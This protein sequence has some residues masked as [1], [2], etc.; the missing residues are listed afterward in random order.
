MAYAAKLINIIGFL[1]KE[2]VTYGTAVAVAGATDAVQP[3]FADRQGIPAQLKYTYAG[4]TGAAPG[5]LG[6]IRNAVPFGATVS[7]D[8]PFF[9]K[10]GGAAYSA[11]VFPLFHKLLKA[12]GLTATG[13]FGAGTENW[14]Y[15]PTVDATVPTSLTVELYTDGEKIPLTGV[16][17]N[18]KCM[19]DGTGLVKHTFTLQGIKGVAADSASSVPAGFTIPLATVVPPS[20]A[21]VTLLIGSYTSAIG[22]KSFDWDLGR[23]LFERPGNEAADAHLGFVHGGRKPRLTVVVEKTALA[24]T[25]F[26]QAGGLDPYKLFES[27]NSFTVTLQH[28]GV[29]YNRW[30]L[31]LTQAQMIAPVDRMP[32][33]G[34]ASMKLQFMPYVSTPVANDDVSLAVD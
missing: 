10:G 20:M 24:T 33:N 13:T 12:A 3:W 26:H 15:A 2:E 4:E 9:F 27:G 28:P 8:I 6:E 17:C 30:K 29:Q 22:V 19:G 7:V 23:V 16:L 21:G 34:V 31:T 11:A 14:A 1:C 18:W 25:P 5:N 32:N